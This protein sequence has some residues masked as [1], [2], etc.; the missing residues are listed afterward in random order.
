MLGTAPPLAHKAAGSDAAVPRFGVV[1][2]ERLLVLCFWGEKTFISLF[3]RWKW[4][5]MLKR[6]IPGKILSDEKTVFHLW[7]I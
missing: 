1:S 6:Y 7:K 4:V 5:K 3:T 2:T